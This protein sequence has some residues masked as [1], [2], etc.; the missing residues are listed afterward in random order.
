MICFNCKA[1][2]EDGSEFCPECG[3]RQMPA[4]GA[5]GLDATQMAPPPDATQ[6]FDATMGAG[7]AAFG[8][9]QAAEYEATQAFH[10]GAAQPANYAQPEP[11]FEA[12][13]VAP[14]GAYVPPVSPK[15]PQPPVPPAPPKKNNTGII[16]AI[17]GAI[18]ILLAVLGVLA[19]KFLPEL[20]LFEKNDKKDSNNKKITEVHTKK[21]DKV[22]ST[23]E[24]LTL[25]EELTAPEIVDMVTIPIAI[26]TVPRG[27]D[28]G[29]IG[30][31]DRFTR[32]A[33]TNPPTTAR[34]KPTAAP[35]TRPR[36]TQSPT[37]YWEATTY[38]YEEPTTDYFL[39]TPYTLVD[40][41]G[42]QAHIAG[43]FYDG[44]SS[45][46]IE[47]G[48]FFVGDTLCFYLSIPDGD[49]VIENV[50]D[51]YTVYIR[52]AGES[53]FTKENISQS[54][55]EE[56]ASTVIDMLIELGYDNKETYPDRLYEYL[57]DSRYGNLGYVEKYNVYEDGD[58][59]GVIYVDLDTG[60]YAAVLDTDGSTIFSASFIDTSGS[61]LPYDYK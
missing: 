2:I 11:D 18:V 50:N 30:S 60:Y 21:D 56:L 38:Y 57:G 31:A 40:V 52:E 7:V 49:I 32:P 54:E 46:Y 4:T 42:N 36:A 44:S 8:A 41:Y 37:Y 39:D 9:N 53:S 34:P 1:V 25:F 6:A 15:Y 45:T 61:M 13:Q 58:F 35:T 47:Y 10:Y 55:C 22:I 23:T 3:C 16:I 20:G 5:P 43:T 48:Y 17:A 59:G 12:T 26:P 29:A 14:Y 33:V 19:F 27:N 28:T 24:S 51:Y